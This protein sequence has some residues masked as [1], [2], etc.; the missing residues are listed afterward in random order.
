MQSS[1]CLECASNLHLCNSVLLLILAV[2]P[3]IRLACVPEPQVLACVRHHMAAGLHLSGA[4]VRAAC[5]RAHADGRAIVLR[6]SR[7]EPHS[8]PAFAAEPRSSNSHHPTSGLCSRLEATSQGNAVGASRSSTGNEV[9]KG[10]GS[11]KHS[12]DGTAAADPAREGGSATD[13]KVCSSAVTSAGPDVSSSSSRADAV[14]QSAAE[15]DVSHPKASLP[16]RPTDLLAS[17]PEGNPLAWHCSGTT[18]RWDIGQQEA[19]DS[20]AASAAQALEGFVFDGKPRGNF[21]RDRLRP[22]QHGGA[23]QQ[24]PPLSDT[25]GDELLLAILKQ[26]VYALAEEDAAAALATPLSP[27]PS[28]AL[29]P[30]PSP[31]PSPQKSV[32]LWDGSRQAPKAQRLVD[33]QRD[34]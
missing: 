31:L 11:V 14:Q 25:E 6:P 30:H 4:V 12:G 20:V 28:A 16:N 18:S 5:C 3:V 17:P 1:K 27:T 13:A 15:E 19:A 33:A 9:R 23:R 8:P 24:P 2:E 32:K 26:H 22:E 34:V 29:S 10:S 21:E 7:P